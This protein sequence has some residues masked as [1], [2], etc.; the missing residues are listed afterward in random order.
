MSID[1]IAKV[2]LHEV[3]YEK[4][5]KGILEGSFRPGEKLNQNSLSKQFGVSRMPV[6]D[7]LRML[8]NES[9]IEYQVNKGHV[10]SD[11]PKK[12]MD[13]I[14]FVRSILEPKA[15]EES[16]KYFTAQAIHTL[17]TIL[18]KSREALKNRDWK[19]LRELNADF[20]FT[21]YNL[22]PSPILNDSIHKLWHSFPKYLFYEQYETN[23]KSLQDHQKLIEHIKNND[24]AA[25]SELMRAHIHAH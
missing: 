2:P 3:I 14:R 10:I 24:F 1:R 22:V 23:Q 7:A 5:K 6:R 25:A 19:L 21:I 8:E 13:D 15:V 16:G 12:K 4:L 9:L 18:D 11:F 17:E 20:H